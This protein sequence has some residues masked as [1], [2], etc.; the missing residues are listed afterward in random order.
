MTLRPI[1]LAFFVLLVTPSI[2]FADE[3]AK[4]AQALIDQ[5]GQKQSLEPAAETIDW[6]GA[7]EAMDP[8]VKAQMGIKSPEDLKA[9][10]LNGYKNIGGEVKT[11]VDRALKNADPQKAKILEVMQQRLQKSLDEQSAKAKQDFAETTYVVGKERIN[12]DT[13][14][15]EVLKG[16]GESQSTVTLQFVKRNGTWKLKSAAPLSPNG[17]GGDEAVTGLLGPSVASPNEAIVRHN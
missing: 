10:Q 11:S 16:R 9:Q 5:M 8:A 7:Y 12:N 3:P 17:N 14:E 4:I 2:A 1:R 13:A 6:Q 15:V